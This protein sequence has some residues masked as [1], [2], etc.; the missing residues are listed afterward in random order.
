MYYFM[1]DIHG[2]SKAYFAMKKYIEFSENDE[3][4][5]LGDIFDGNTGCP[6]ECL[7]ILDDIMENDN[8]TLILGEHEYFHAM[9]YL[10]KND[11]R[12][13]S[14]YK[15]QLSKWSFGG[16]VL[17]EYLESL[18]EETYQK[19][20]Q[21][22]LG[23]EVSKVLKIGQRYFYLVHGAPV[24]CN[25]EKIEEW[26]E[27]V[28]VSEIDVYKNYI[29]EVLND[30]NNNCINQNNYQN[31]IIMC[32]HRDINDMMLDDK[33]IKEMNAQGANEGYQKIVFHNKIMNINCGC[34]GDAYKAFFHPT[35]ACVCLDEFDDRFFVQYYSNL[36]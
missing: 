14:K 12:A 9:H 29:N 10:E 24:L 25:K 15:N 7:K 16:K 21:Y 18:T 30:P 2:N 4:Y 32:G 36:F 13:S 19:Y 28:V 17:M 22:L 35:L 1:S 6:G 34:R 20:M 5:I 33:N 8:I 23:C 11:Y 3:L 31:V 27:K 26:Q